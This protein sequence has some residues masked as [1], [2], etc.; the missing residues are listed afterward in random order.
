MYIIYFLQY[1]QSFFRCVCPAG[2]SGL[3]CEVNIDD[4]I[5]NKCQNN[6]TCLDKVGEYECE[7]QPG[8]EGQF[9]DTKTAFCSGKTGPCLNGGKCRDHST[10]YTCECPAGFSGQN[11]TINID[12]CANHMCQ[13]GGT[14]VDGIDEYTCQCT[15]EFTGKFCEIE[16]MVAQLYPKTSPCQQHDCKH[17]M[18]MV[19]PGSNDYMCKCAPGY[20][21]K[22]C[23]YLTSLTFSHNNSFV[24]ME[25]LN[26][27]PHAN[28]TITF[29]TDQENGVLLY[30][31]D[32]THLAVELFRGR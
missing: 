21:G 6:A 30:T 22:R 31:G 14:C 11:C 9:C 26:V 17:G 12:D 19:L 10:H 1:G 24:E 15:A 7:C 20:S 25:R 5:G 29:A 16:P 28:V 18:C 23:E 8:F 27:K 32:F 3:R 2:F 13:N 4:C